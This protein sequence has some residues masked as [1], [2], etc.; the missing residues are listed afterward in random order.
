MSAQRTGNGNGVPS[1]PFNN[2]NENNQWSALSIIGV[3]VTVLGF[4]AVV[5]FIFWIFRKEKALRRKAAA[6]GDILEPST[7]E[8]PDQQFKDKRD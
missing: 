7:G 1:F 6:E 3:V 5:W 4:I 2:T 8:S